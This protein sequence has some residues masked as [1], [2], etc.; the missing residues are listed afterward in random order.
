MLPQRLWLPKEMSEPPRLAP[1]APGPIEP[2]YALLINPF[3]PKD[4]NASFGKHVLT[5]SLALTSFAATTPAHWRIEYWDENLLDGAPPWQPM[6][7]VVGITVHLTFA[8]RAYELAHWF[9]ARGS[10][11]ILGGLHVLSCPDECAP[12]ADALALGDGVQLWPRILADVEAGR[13]ETRY[14]ATYETDY[15]SDP[16]PRR[17]LL[18]RR[19]FLT[20]S[21]L[22][23]TR[24][25]HNRCEFCYLAT[26]GL[27]MPYRMR[28]PAQVAAEFEASGEPYA[29]FIDN[30]LGSR[31]EYLRALCGALQPL[32]KIWSAAVTI[33]VTDDPSLVRAM[34]LAGCTGV[35]VGFESLSDENL[36]NAHKKTPKAADYARRVR[37]LH[38]HGIQVNGSF[39]LGFDCDGRDVFARTAEWVETNRLECATF[40]ILTPYPATPLFRRMEAEGRILHRDWTLYD[41]AHAVFQP[42]RM[43]PEELEEGYA[44]VYRRLFSHAS[45]WRRRP[46]DWRSI[47]PYLAMSYLYKRSNRFWHLLIRHDL[48]HTV[49]QPLVELTR[50]RH[51]QFRRRLADRA[52]PANAVGIITAGV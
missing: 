44:W 21:S 9:R 37:L 25:C 46:E 45:I 33:D 22:I 14:H 5:P 11:V 42:R 48:V 4:P 28:D 23:A 39:V 19:S 49:W 6:P 20:T 35:F 3:Y 13:L 10:K 1:V 16:A 27:R 24:G 2:R 30:N 36:L 43:S 17:S 29:V 34:A 41:T 51:L 38:E 50:L 8:R 32:E 18:P 12:H 26:E 7:E 15:R 52:K 40:H 31:R 47:A